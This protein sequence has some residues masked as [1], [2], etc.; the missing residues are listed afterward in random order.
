MNS[1]SSHRCRIWTHERWPEAP[2]TTE[3]EALI[4]Q[5]EAC[6]WTRA[7][8]G[9]IKAGRRLTSGRAFSVQN[10]NDLLG[11]AAKIG[12][13]LRNQHILGYHDFRLLASRQRR[14]IT[15]PTSKLDA[16]QRSKELRKPLS[17]SRLSFYGR[18]TVVTAFEIA[19]MHRIKS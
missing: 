19:S 1:S 9:R 16:A 12:T 15:R 7:Q 11:I 18:N 14:A 5:R 10:P 17:A 8:I 6:A 4:G 2:L 3:G 13:E